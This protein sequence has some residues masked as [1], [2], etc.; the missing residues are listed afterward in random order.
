M[1]ANRPI[2]A[3]LGF[4]EAGG[5]FAGGLAE[6]EVATLRAYDLKLEGPEAD[7]KRAEL[8]GAGAAQ[9]ADAV[10]LGPG[11]AAIFSL[12]TAD[13]AGVAAEAAAP[14][15]AGGVLYF[16]C[17]SCA[18][19]LKRANAALIEAA[20]GRHVDVAVMSAVHPRRHR[21]PLLVSGPHRDAALDLLQRLGMVASDAG[22]EVG[23]ASGIK[24]ARS[25]MVKGFEA[26]MC[27]SLMA[28]RAMGVEDRV[29]ASLDD[30]HPGFD[31]RGLATTL[32]GMPQ[33]G[34]RRAWEM[35]AA[36]QMVDALGLP[37]G[38]AAE[39]ALWERRVGEAG[40]VPGEN[41]A[42][43]GDAL[44]AALAPKT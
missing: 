13:Q 39:T 20:G 21:S 1:T 14:G 36:A 28:A 6:T 29:L 7:V 25:I 22:E 43:T 26:L 33:H 11:A 24:L 9:M 40:L 41:A 8:S 38:L 32:A 2:I 27:E 4:G 18:P 37:G 17:N 23:D 42:Q 19:Q 10:A 35:E 3:F 31:W 15:C 34:V 12:V 44:L 5:A 30:S 16:D